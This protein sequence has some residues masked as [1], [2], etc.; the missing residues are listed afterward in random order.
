MKRLT[1]TQQLWCCGTCA[2]QT[3]PSAISMPISS[4]Q[5]PAAVSAP[6]CHAFCGGTASSWPTPLPSAGNRTRSS[7]SALRSCWN[8]C[9][10]TSSSS[11]RRRKAAGAY[12]V[13]VSTGG[14]H[15]QQRTCSAATLP[16]KMRTRTHARTRYPLLSTAC[17]QTSEARRTPLRTVAVVG[18]G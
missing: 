3:N 2:L 1:A 12:R 6:T 18:R 4:W 17:T 16:S 11:T 8:V 7:A 9:E 15:R 13:R 5:A 14:R 10:S